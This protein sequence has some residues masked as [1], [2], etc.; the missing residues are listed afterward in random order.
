MADIIDLTP[1][2]PATVSFTLN[3]AG[4][5]LQNLW[6]AFD[7]SKYDVL[8]LELGIVNI[9]GTLGTVTIDLYTGM[10]IQ[11][12]DGW[13]QVKNVT[14]GVSIWGT[15]LAV[16]AYVLASQSLG[17]LRY[18]RWQVTTPLSAGQS[19]TFFI[20]GIGRTYAG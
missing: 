14:T 11:T 20:R 8:D 15:G 6:D 13:V 7:V 10:Q 18:I 1:S 9:G 2:E 12:E 16:G 3:G 17:F 4:P 19:V 5:T